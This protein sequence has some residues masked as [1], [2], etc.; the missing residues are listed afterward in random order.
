M[1]NMLPPQDVER[2]AVNMAA[3]ARSRHTAKSYRREDLSRQEVEDLLE[4]L[5]FSSSS[6]NSQPWHFV[7]AS[8]AS[9]R[10]RIARAGTDANNAFNSDAIR[11]A[12]LV[13]VFAARLNADQSYLDRLLETED[14]HGRF[15]D[16]ANKTEWRSIR[17][18]FVDLNRS[19]GD[20]GAHQ[21]MARQVYW[22]GGQF[23]HSA[24]AM[25]L[26]ATPMEGIDGEALD[27]EFGLAEKGYRSLFAIAVG[28]NA[29]ESDWNRQLPKSRL[30]MEETVTR[31]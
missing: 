11:N 13:V 30:S 12:G 24:A 22:N 29:D 7:V 9:G 23:L 8:D 28:R 5:R 2:F 27:R 17:A 1:D 20:P 6:V 16:P 18:A 10:D 4:L 3:I 25:G 19:Q 26:D 15:A 21:W 31:L 14:R